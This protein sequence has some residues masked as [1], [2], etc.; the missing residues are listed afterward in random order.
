ME[1]KNNIQKHSIIAGFLVSSIFPLLIFSDSYY[2][3]YLNIISYFGEFWNSVFWGIIF[4]LVIVFLFWHSAKK[5]NFLLNQNSH[6]KAS[7]KFSFRIG[8]KFAIALITIYLLGE[9][10][11]RVSYVFL[12]YYNYMIIIA[13]TIILELTFILIILTF[14]SS[15]IIVKASQNT[16]TLNQTK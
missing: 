10:A 6:L 13:L 11:M 9:F 8:L 12:V 3:N 14:I 4:P 15:L 2:V 16:Q 5:L 1:P 7:F